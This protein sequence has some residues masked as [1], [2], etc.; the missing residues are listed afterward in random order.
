[1]QSCSA[2]KNYNE[3]YMNKVYSSEYYNCPSPKKNKI[4]RREVN[5]FLKFFSIFKIKKKNF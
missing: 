2:N 3:K 4:G 5:K 1:M